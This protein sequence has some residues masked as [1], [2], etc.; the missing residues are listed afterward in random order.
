MP[1]IPDGD[2]RADGTAKFP[3]T[4]VIPPKKPLTPYMKFSKSASV[5]VLLCAENA[6]LLYSET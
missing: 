5:T 1:S 2:L 3:L 6:L 4:T